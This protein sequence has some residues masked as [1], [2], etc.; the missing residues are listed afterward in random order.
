M[1]IRTFKD[2]NRLVI[3]VEGLENIPSDEEVLGKFIKSI[4]GCDKTDV[5]SQ[6]EA[7]PVPVEESDPCIIVKTSFYEG[8]VEG[9]YEHID[10][11]QKELELLSELGENSELYLR[12]KFSKMDGKEYSEK[13]SPVQKKKFFEIYGRY[14]PESIVEDFDVQKAIDFYK[15]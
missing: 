10:S 9:A 12:H 3:V 2:G 5:F 7:I 14:M 15:S 4:S 1:N 6:A 13:L 11:V 8:P